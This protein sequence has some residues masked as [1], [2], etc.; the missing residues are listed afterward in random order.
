MARKQKLPPGRPAGSF[1][2][3]P[4]L[5]WRSRGGKVSFSRTAPLSSKLPLT[6]LPSVVRHFLETTLSFLISNETLQTLTNAAPATAAP[7]CFIYNRDNK[8]K[9]APAVTLGQETLGPLRLTGW[10]CS[11]PVSCRSAFSCDPLW[12]EQIS[13]P[14]NELYRSYR[15][16]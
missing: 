1:R 12:Q 5:R 8:R 3:D 11:H 6:S 2:P 9:M 14:N 13:K 10:D 16:C 7:R 4:R 15:Y